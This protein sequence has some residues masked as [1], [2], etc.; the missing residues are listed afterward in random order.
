M[1]NDLLIGDK[2]YLIRKGF[3]V[4]ICITELSGDI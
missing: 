1:L 3:T 4:S 2:P